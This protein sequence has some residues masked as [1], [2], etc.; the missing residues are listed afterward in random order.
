[1]KRLFDKYGI[2]RPLSREIQVR[3]L[4]AKKR[5]FTAILKKLGIF[6]PLYGLIV[7]V[8][9]FMKEVGIGLTLVQSAGLFFIASSITTAAITTGGYVIIKNALVKPPRQEEKQEQKV[10]DRQAPL[11]LDEEAAVR[12]YGRYSHVV[13]FYGL[14][15]NGAE[16]PIVA[17]VSDI[18]KNE[19]IRLKGRGK[20][21]VIPSTPGS[22]TLL[23]GSV[24]K[25]GGKYLLTLR[26][27]DRRTQRIIFAASESAATVELLKKTGI[28]MAGELS[29]KMQ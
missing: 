19:I 25:L 8:Y 14:E 1:M 20:I 21:A 28:R 6:T 23:T 27:T 5:N 10:N 15:N 11:K 13:Q 24:E 3:A 18:I 22:R 12:K 17:Q 16:N 9:F 4:N 2:S 26:L 29:E 7:S